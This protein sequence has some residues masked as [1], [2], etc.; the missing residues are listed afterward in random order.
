MANITNVE[1]MIFVSYQI[2]PIPAAFEDSLYQHLF[3]AVWGDRS[4]V[5]EDIC[6]SQNLLNFIKIQSVLDQS[7]GVGVSQGVC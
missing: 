5:D 6:M 4:M 1:T 2:E 3:D 7:G